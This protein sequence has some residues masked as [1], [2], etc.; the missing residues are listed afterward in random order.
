MRTI[1]GIY[2]IDADGQ[3][4]SYLRGTT[5]ADIPSAITPDGQR[6][7]YIHQGDATGADVYLTTLDADRKTTELVAT[8]GYDGGA[9]FSPDGTLLAYVSNESGPYEVY[10]RETVASGKGLLI[11]PDGGTQPK[12]SRDGR[13]LFFRTGNRMYVVDVSRSG[14]WKASPPRV[15]FEQRFAYG[16][17]QTLA[18]YDVLAD[19]QHFVMVK[20][21]TSAGHVNIVLNWFQDLNRLVPLR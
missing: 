2:Q 21:D 16:S 8:A 9:Q 14:G 17:S 7:A 18:N 20:D 15:L 4:G 19:G 3:H 1:A 5:G 6:L 11:S 13:E 12:W 10:V